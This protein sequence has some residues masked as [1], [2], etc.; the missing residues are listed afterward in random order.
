LPILNSGFPHYKVRLA[1]F[2]QELTYIFS[3]VPGTKK[4]LVEALSLLLK[5]AVEEGDN[6]KEACPFSMPGRD[7]ENDVARWSAPGLR[8]LRRD[9][10]RAACLRPS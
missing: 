9:L 4:R 1:I 7:E 10:S 2:S 6:S 5:G 8:L 3:D